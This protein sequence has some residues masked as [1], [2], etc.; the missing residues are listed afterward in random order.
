MTADTATDT[1]LQSRSQNAKRVSIVEAAARVFASEGFAAANIDVIATE[2]GVSRQTVYNHH[3]DKE[4]LFVAVVRE[5]TDRANAR[6][7]ETLDSFP[8]RPQD[9][10]A[11]LVEFALRLTRNCICNRDSKFLRKMILMEGSRYP[12]LFL[13][14]REEGP[15]RVS[16]ALAARFARLALSGWLELADPDVAARQFF[17]LINADLHISTML[18]DNP[19]EEQL[20]ISADNAVKTFLRAFGKQP[21]SGLSA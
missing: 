21:R 1:L 17:A 20:R 18:G 14:W 12:A 3:G 8:D 2:A 19:S 6:F 15:G 10:H 11:E 5:I 7:F 9:L 16:S 13:H 4:T